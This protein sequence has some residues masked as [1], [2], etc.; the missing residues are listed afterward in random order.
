M[1]HAPVLCFLPKQLSA[2]NLGSLRIDAAAGQQC[3]NDIRLAIAGGEVQ[4]RR[5]HLQYSRRR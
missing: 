1:I 5:T 4:R 2:Y 3:T